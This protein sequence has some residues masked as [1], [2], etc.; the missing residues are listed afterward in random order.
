MFLLSVAGWVADSFPI[1]RIVI[2]TLMV[3]IGLAL[4]VVIMFQPSSSS[5]MGALTGQ[6]DTFYSKD[7][8][9]SLESVMK[10]LTAILGIVEG[11][12][13]ILFFVTLIIYH[14]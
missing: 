9:K 6:R 14:G 4:I 3:A 7:K 10:R 13:A 12:L 8:S 11:V 2:I 1:I 5:G